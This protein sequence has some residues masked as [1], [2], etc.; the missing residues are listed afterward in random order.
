MNNRVDGIDGEGNRLGGHPINLDRATLVS[1]ARLDANRISAWRGLQARVADVERMIDAALREEWDI[2]LNWFDVLAGLQRLGGTARPTALADEVGLPM[3]SLTRRLDRLEEDGWVTRQR[4]TIGGDHRA[5][6]VALTARGRT[7]WRAM[8]VTYRRA[9]Q[10]LFAERMDDD[11]I[12][13]IHLAIEMMTPIPV[14]E[15]DPFDDYM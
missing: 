12:Q 3:S 7:L 15:E 8:N 14:I 11:L 9:V 5:M 10:S 6:Q 1:M 4:V 13:A 2:P